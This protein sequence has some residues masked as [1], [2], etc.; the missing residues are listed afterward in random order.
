MRRIQPA[1][2]R[3]TQ[4]STFT[5]ARQRLRAG[6][7]AVAALLDQ[8]AEGHCLAH[9][10]FESRPDPPYARLGLRVAQPCGVRKWLVA[11]SSA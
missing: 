11:H 5:H 10:F 9:T 7:S 6:M 1:I 4:E 2:G 8:I 3:R